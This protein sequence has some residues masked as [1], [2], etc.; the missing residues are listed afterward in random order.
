MATSAPQ[1][2][3]VAPAS[4][5]SGQLPSLG[6]AKGGCIFCKHPLRYTFVD[7]GMSPLCENWLTK[8]DLH[9]G[10]S[11]YPLHAF[12]CEKCFL[13][14]VEEYVHGEEIFGGESR[15][16]LRRGLN[17]PGVM[18]KP[19]PNGSASINQALS[20]SWPLTTVIC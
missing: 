10:E 15:R 19:L 7:L 6:N 5:E 3:P 4:R 17:M 18:S 14:Q 2:P 13:V 20:W 11:F 12:V 8:E 1:S 9:E 16:F